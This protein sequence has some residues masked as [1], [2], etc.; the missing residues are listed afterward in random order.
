MLTV[1]LEN[2][3]YCDSSDLRIVDACDQVAVTCKHCHAI[4]PHADSV[5]K[6][7]ARWNRRAGSLPAIFFEVP[8]N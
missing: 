5:A 6:A 7:A 2:C 3:P 1:G 8:L 4:G